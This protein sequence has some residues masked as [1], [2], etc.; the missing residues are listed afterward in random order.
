MLIK[1]THTQ[2]A[3]PDEVRVEK[4]KDRI[5]VLYA[6]LWESVGGLGVVKWTS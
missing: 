2:D 1:E 4:T 3:R 5:M 6:S